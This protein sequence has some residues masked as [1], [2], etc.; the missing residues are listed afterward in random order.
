M[1]KE[2]LDSGRNATRRPGR[3]FPETPAFKFLLS[4]LLDPGLGLVGGALDRL[5]GALGGALRPFA[6]FVGR[7]LDRLASARRRLVDALRG[8]LRRAL[9]AVGRRLLV[10]TIGRR[11][12]EQPGEN[13][14]ESFN[15]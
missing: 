3:L 13:Q 7:A 10:R 11:R 9:D 5:A 14:R 1:P 4:L 8:F 12:G 6:G 15:R 2:M